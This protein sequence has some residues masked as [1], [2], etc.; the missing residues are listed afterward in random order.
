MA[1]SQVEQDS[2]FAEADPIAAL[3]VRFRDLDQLL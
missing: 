3:C 2:E 1:L